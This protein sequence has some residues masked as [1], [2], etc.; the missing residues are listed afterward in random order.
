[1]SALFL[2]DEELQA[3]L[4]TIERLADCAS[5]KA[6]LALDDAQK[7]RWFVTSGQRDKWARERIKTL[8]AQ[9]AEARA[10]IE[11]AVEPEAT[12]EKADCGLCA[13]WDMDAA[14][15]LADHRSA[16][17]EG[18]LTKAVARAIKEAAQRDYPLRAFMPQARAAIRVINTARFGQS[19]E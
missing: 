15:W 12:Q 19:D 17:E 7:A 6:F 18:E 14:R 16:L 2:T 11:Q 1:M 5:T 4:D 3:K 9:L 13:Q 10:L 8:E